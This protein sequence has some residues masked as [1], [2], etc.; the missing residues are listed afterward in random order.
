MRCSSSKVRLV[1]VSS[2]VIDMSEFSSSRSLND[3]DNNYEH[4]YIYNNNNNIHIIT[5]LQDNIL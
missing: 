5:E 3:R 1:S 2:I 4:L